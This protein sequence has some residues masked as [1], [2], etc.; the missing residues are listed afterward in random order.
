MHLLSNSKPSAM[1]IIRFINTA[2]KTD[3]E[4]KMD[5]WQLIKANLIIVFIFAVLFMFIIYFYKFL[6]N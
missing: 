5:N 6:I 1:N 4:F 2:L 3:I